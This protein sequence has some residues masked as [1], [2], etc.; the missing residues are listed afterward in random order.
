MRYAAFLLGG[1]LFSWIGFFEP[2]HFR[3]GDIHD[4]AM[5]IGS[6]LEGIFIFTKDGPRKILVFSIF[7][8]GGLEWKVTEVLSHIAVSH[9]AIFWDVFIS[10]IFLVEAEELWAFELGVIEFANAIAGVIWSD[11]DFV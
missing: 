10:P 8:V 1:K 5:T 2:R 11:A 6:A 4:R 9:D 7:E 3:C